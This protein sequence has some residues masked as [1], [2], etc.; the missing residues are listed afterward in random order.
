MTPNPYKIAGLNDVRNNPSSHAIDFLNLPSNYILTIFDVSGQIILQV[1]Q[2][3]A[4]DGKF[5]WTMFS[6]DGT[7]VGSGLYIY[8]VQYGG[9]CTADEPASSCSFDK[10]V[11]GHFAI[12]R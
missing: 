5:T 10:E 9:S 6:K 7:E 8:H 1:E 4:V 12:M 11:T 3:D 2:T